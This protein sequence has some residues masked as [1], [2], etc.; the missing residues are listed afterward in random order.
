VGDPYKD[1]S[2]PAISILVK[3]TCVVALRAR[4]LVRKTVGGEGR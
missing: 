3:V 4:A 1:T 2:G